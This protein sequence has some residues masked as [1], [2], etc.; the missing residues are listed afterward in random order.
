MAADALIRLPKLLGRRHDQPA[1]LWRIARSEHLNLQV[2][3]NYSSAPVVARAAHFAPSTDKPQ[4]AGD[5]AAGRPT[6]Q[7]TGNKGFRNMKALLVIATLLASSPVVAQTDQP[8]QTKSGIIDTLIKRA[9]TIRCGVIRNDLPDDAL[10]SDCQ[11]PA[12]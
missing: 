1:R 3:H 9:D 10:L 8:A 5:S 2:G 4:Q 7:L 11:E 6:T 12:K